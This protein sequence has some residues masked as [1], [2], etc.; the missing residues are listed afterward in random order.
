MAFD[1]EITKWTNPLH[2][3]SME[4]ESEPAA[5]ASVGRTPEADELDNPKELEGEESPEERRARLQDE[6][7]RKKY[8]LEDGDEVTREQFVRLARAN[9]GFGLARGRNA[10]GEQEAEDK[11]SGI[12]F[13]TL[14]IDKEQAE[15]QGATGAKTLT[16]TELFAFLETA[17]VETGPIS[18]R[19]AEK[20]D[21]T[22]KETKEAFENRP[23]YNWRCQRQGKLS[24]AEVEDLTNVTFLR[25]SEVKNIELLFDEIRTNNFWQ[26]VAADNLTGDQRWPDTVKA[27]KVAEPYMQ[28][29]S[30]QQLR[31]NLPEFQNNLFF[32]RLVRLFSSTGEPQLTLYELIDLYSALSPRADVKWKVKVWFCVFDF[33]EDGVLHE[34]DLRTTI[35]RMMR[36]TVQTNT[37]SPDE[38]AQRIQAR[39]SNFQQV[40]AKQEK[41]AASGDTNGEKD[42]MMQ[43]E[44]LSKLTGRNTMLTVKSQADVDEKIKKKAKSAKQPAQGP[45]Q[46][47]AI[48][49]LRTCT[50]IRRNVMEYREFETRLTNYPAFANNFSVQMTEVSQLRKLLKDRRDE[51]DGVQPPWYREWSLAK[52]R[53]A[54]CRSKGDDDDDDDDDQRQQQQQQ[55]QQQQSS[56]SSSS[57]SSGAPVSMDS[58]T[59]DSQYTGSSEIGG[60]LSPRSSPRSPGAGA[61]IAASPRSRSNR[62]GGAGRA[63]LLSFSFLRPDAKALEAQLQGLTEAQ[64]IDK[65][66]GGWEI[67]DE[68]GCRAEAE[69]LVQET[70]ADAASGRIRE[71][72]CTLV[73][74]QHDQHMVDWMWPV[75]G[76]AD[77][78]I[79][80][81]SIQQSKELIKRVPTRHA[82]LRKKNHDFKRTDFWRDT[83]QLIDE[84]PQDGGGIGGSIDGLGS[85]ETDTQ[86]EGKKK[87]KNKNS[88]KQSG[89]GE[90]KERED[91]WT[92]PELTEVLIHESNP[93]CR[94]STQDSADM[95]V[96]PS[97]QL[98][99]AVITK[100][101]F[102]GWWKRQRKETPEM[103]TYLRRL[104]MLHESDDRI[105]EK[106]PWND[107]SDPLKMIDP[108]KKKQGKTAV[109]KC[110]VKNIVGVIWAHHRKQRIQEDNEDDYDGKTEFEKE[111]ATYEENM[112]MDGKGLPSW[113]KKEEKYPFDETFETWWKRWMEVQKKMDKHKSMPDDWMSHKTFANYWMQRSIWGP[114][115]DDNGNDEIKKETARIKKERKETA[116]KETSEPWTRESTLAQWTKEKDEGLWHAI[117]VRWE[118][119]M[120]TLDIMW[121]QADA[122]RS[123]TVSLKEAR[124]LLK[125]VVGLNGKRLDTVRATEEVNEMVAKQESGQQLGQP[126]KDGNRSERVSKL[127]EVVSSQDVPIRRS[128]KESSKPTGAVFISGQKIVVLKVS[129]DGS[130]IQCK[131]GWVSMKDKDKN[132]QLREITR[133]KNSLK[134]KYIIDW[135]QGQP[136]VVKRYTHRRQKL[137]DAWASSVMDN[138]HDDEESLMQVW[139]AERLLWMLWGQEAKDDTDKH[140]LEKS[141]AIRFAEWWTT[142]DKGKT[143]TE[144]TAAGITE[145]G[146]DEAAM[147][148][149]NGD[150]QITLDEFALWWVHQS[151]NIQELKHSKK[152]YEYTG[153][154]LALQR[155]EEWSL[156]NVDATHTRAQRLRLAMNRL[157]EE[158]QGLDSAAD[159]DADDEPLRRALAKT[160]LKWVKDKHWHAF[161]NSTATFRSDCNRPPMIYTRIK[162]F[163]SVQNLPTLMTYRVMQDRVKVTAES[164][165][166]SQVVEELNKGRVIVSTEVLNRRVKFDGGWVSIEEMRRGRKVVALKRI[167]QKQ[168]RCSWFV[169]D[170]C[171][172]QGVPAWWN[173]WLTGADDFEAVANDTH[174]QRKAA[175]LAASRAHGEVEMNDVGGGLLDIN[176]MLS[177]YKGVKSKRCLRLR[178]WFSHRIADSV[179]QPTEWLWAKDLKSLNDKYGHGVYHLMK[180]VRYMVILNFLLGLMWML[181]LIIP[182]IHNQDAKDYASESPVTFTFTASVDRLV[183]GGTVAT[184]ES[185]TVMWH[186]T[187]LGTLTI[188]AK[189]IFL[190]GQNDTVPTLLYSKYPKEPLEWWFGLNTR[191]DLL[192]FVAILLHLSISFAMLMRS[193]G[194]SLSKLARGGENFTSS[195]GIHIGGNAQHDTTSF[196]QI[197]GGYNCTITDEAECLAMRQI[198]RAKLDLWLKSYTETEE[199]RKSFTKCWPWFKHS[200]VGLLGKIFTWAIFAAYL[201]C[202]AFTVTDA[203]DFF[204][205]LH[206]GFLATLPLSLMD[207]VVPAMI[208][209]IVRYEKHFHQSKELQVVLW[210]IFTVKTIQFVVVL[211]S[212]LDMAETKHTCIEDEFGKTFLRLVL[213][214]A[215]VV[216]SSDLFQVFLVKHGVPRL[217]RWAEDTKRFAS[218]RQVDA[219]QRGRKPEYQHRYYV[220]PRRT[221]AEDEKKRKEGHQWWRLDPYCE[222]PLLS[223]DVVKW[224]TGQSVVNE[225]IRKEQERS[226]AIRFDALSIIAQLMID[227]GFHTQH[228]V[229][230]ADGTE[231]SYWWYTQNRGLNPKEL[232][233]LLREQRRKRVAM[234]ETEHETLEHHEDSDAEDDVAEGLGREEGDDDDTPSMQSLFARVKEIEARKRGLFGDIVVQ[235]NQLKQAEEALEKAKQQ[236]RDAEQVDDSR[237]RD[238][239]QANLKDKQRALESLR[240]TIDA[241]NRTLEQKRRRDL[242]A[243]KKQL[244]QESERLHVDAK[245][246]VT[247]KQRMRAERAHMQVVL[248]TLPLRLAKQYK[249]VDANHWE[250]YQDENTQNDGYSGSVPDLQLEQMLLHTPKSTEQKDDAKLQNDKHSLEVMIDQS[251]AAQ[252]LVDTLFKL[253]K[254]KKKH[255][256]NGRRSLK[257][258][259]S[260]EEQHA[261]YQLAAGQ[262][263][264][265]FMS[266]KDD[267][268]WTLDK[269]TALGMIKAVFPSLSS[270]DGDSEKATGKVFQDM[271]NDARINETEL[272]KEL[273]GWRPLAL[274]KRATS[275]GV[276]QAALKS[277][278]ESADPRADP[279]EQEDQVKAALIELLLKQHASAAS[280]DAGEQSEET[281]SLEQFIFWWRHYD[282]AV[283][284]RLLKEYIKW[285]GAGKPKDKVEIEQGGAG[286]GTAAKKKAPSHARERYTEWLT[287]HHLQTLLMA[288]YDTLVYDRSKLYAQASSKDEIA[289]DEKYR[290]LR[291]AEL[292]KTIILLTLNVDVKAQLRLVKE[293]ITHWRKKENKAA[294]R[295]RLTDERDSA[296]A[297]KEQSLVDKRGGSKVDGVGAAAG[298]GSVAGGQGA[299]DSDKALTWV[300]WPLLLRAYN[301]ALR[302]LETDDDVLKR[303]SEEKKRDKADRSKS[304]SMSCISICLTC[305]KKTTKGVKN[306]IKNDDSCRR[307]AEQV[308]LDAEREGLPHQLKRAIKRYDMVL[309][310]KEERARLLKFKQALEERQAELKQRM[311]SKYNEE[312]DGYSAQI[313]AVDQE[314]DE[315]DSAEAIAFSVKHGASPKDIRGNGSDD[316]IDPTATR[317]SGSASNTEEIAHQRRKD[318]NRLVD[319]VQNHQRDKVALAA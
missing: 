14:V 144:M 268:S 287:Y 48:D 101:A 243:R 139:Q 223:Q 23:Y 58:P 274:Q 137:R 233:R 118:D 45:I 197:V 228:D 57:S 284:L 44:T 244:E 149:T 291:E 260:L 16:Y 272:R 191:T 278:L 208:R 242:N 20:L 106:S 9:K 110:V 250:N 257:K 283:S 28:T 158:I 2:S 67:F 294:E 255:G 185:K 135:W 121:V 219:L 206:L 122:N 39:W 50:S 138:I 127:F 276:S 318:I 134:E 117:H 65:A 93:L 8:N 307:W 146:E 76:G 64:L 88:A 74:E 251:E 97:G 22:V 18:E 153:R 271:I 69:Q 63:E 177:T 200:M 152:E 17:G 198:N 15:V 145:L 129:K 131:E 3:E 265:E 130:A 53:P 290:D 182:F 80:R 173:R 167:D 124:D 95:L 302:V 125:A 296:K 29:L 214:D 136:W 142:F 194:L 300:K 227:A 305:T 165:D 312:L 26:D 36:G 111:S 245:A 12:V 68:Y 163:K 217:W 225:V 213:T 151:K 288:A 279:R 107:W 187:V 181:V 31:Q 188:V 164:G 293:M 270:V 170:C 147:S 180:T 249:E 186:R 226:T 212:L 61:A 123:G 168:R 317:P 193:L 154:Q 109:R 38:A 7:L 230:M 41:E 303:Q 220:P 120:K 99:E 184:I 43:Q 73:I 75:A 314:I 81:R 286:D 77:G 209:W 143:G 79:Q 34:G 100:E 247:L 59:R 292:V 60:G 176:T 21:S 105:G 196:A 232:A 241:H 256:S 311:A 239:A 115:G 55:Q 54:C 237:Q 112:T 254:T 96:D 83:L 133:K 295:D 202:V 24:H 33:D 234:V 285:W 150:G 19:I 201:V 280:A 47:Y 218:G 248:G 87:K 102:A 166:G 178:L 140:T 155:G 235:M 258:A 273:D 25:H 281:V 51:I 114:D 132:P 216:I 148:K 56:S 49:V 277:A 108:E 236:R 91:G 299:G 210:R 13:D 84:Q 40:R 72:L 319:H 224:A 116:D 190:S 246:K 174:R 82:R 310:P 267:R 30:M 289:T 46:S 141:F 297:A 229:I 11:F 192:Y 35:A 262:I 301:N 306:D 86:C 205:S 203:Q 222:E 113:C 298:S 207:T 94:L 221:V 52:L 264:I 42:K 70:A 156:D 128:Q 309:S 263:F 238:E 85:S 10:A 275:A 252:L 6:R 316:G 157:D 119:S 103:E 172:G 269:D 253:S 4:D 304:Q 27:A 62:G 160:Q 308:S 162:A 89:V 37:M 183:G 215:I 71:K 104:R 282:D 261:V 1:A 169:C 98:Q 179:D 32:D 195:A 78:K 159:V 199:K 204:E 171:V 92:A 175:T 189:G 161:G 90:L 211:L 315:I 266:D 259:L 231:S 5:A 126:G 66:H 240:S 313:V